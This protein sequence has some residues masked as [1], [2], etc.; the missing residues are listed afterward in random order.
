[1]ASIF[2]DN[3]ILSREKHADYIE[4][5]DTTGAYMITVKS[6]NLLGSFATFHICGGVRNKIIK[7]ITSV[8][9]KNG[10][11]LVIRWPNNSIP[12]LAYE[13]PSVAPIEA[14]HYNLKII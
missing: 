3:I 2:T 11:E 4:F 14:L 5:C 12:I 9:G 6:E 7:R 13:D 8:C 10:E 1:M